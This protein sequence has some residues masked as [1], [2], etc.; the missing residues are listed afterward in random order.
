M[1]E[2]AGTRVRAARPPAGW[3]RGSARRSAQGSGGARGPDRGER[4]AT[5]AEARTWGGGGASPPA[6]GSALRAERAASA[7]LAR[8]RSSAGRPWGDSALP[9]A[10]AACW[11]IA[12]GPRPGG[13][14]SRSV[15]AGSA[16]RGTVALELFHLRWLV[17]DL[18]LLRCCVWMLR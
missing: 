6:A 5:P 4:G 1:R 8:H 16:G 14:G 17:N 10:P 7:S 9:R 2:G 18:L 12:P 13:R 11:A 3:R 15:L